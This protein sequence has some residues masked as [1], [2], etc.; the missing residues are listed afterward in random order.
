MKKYKTTI[1]ASIVI[2]VA[3]TAFFIFRAFLP[4]NDDG[5]GDAQEEINTVE[6]VSFVPSD[7]NKIDLYD[8]TNHILMELKYD[9]DWAC[10][11]ATELP[12]VQANVKSFLTVL[13][14]ARGQVVYEGEITEEK[15]ETYGIDDKKYIDYTLT[16][17]TLIR[18]SVGVEKPGASSSYVCVTGDP[19]NQDRIYL[20]T[21]T[22]LDTI[23]FDQHDLISTTIFAFEDPGKIRKMEIYK[24]G[25]LFFSADA[26][27]SAEQRAWNAT[28]PINRQGSYENIESVLSACVSLV[29]AGY[30]ESNPENLTKYGLDVPYF[31]LAVTDNKQTIKMTLGDLNPEGTHYYCLVS[32]MDHI[33]TIQA[34]TITFTDEPQLAFIYEY[35]YMVNYAD[36]TQLKFSYDG[37]DYVLTY[38]IFEEDE[39]LYFNGINVYLDKERDYRFEFKKIGTSLY[40]IAIDTIEP[41]PQHTDEIIIDIEYTLKDGTV[42][43]VT[44][45]KRDDYTYCAYVNGEYI[46]GYSNTRGLTGTAENYGLAGCIKDL[47]SLLGIDD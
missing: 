18:L 20:I 23:F 44:G 47:E 1:I 30:V 43:T 42:V 9:G 39:N 21:S 46:G 11:T 29:T 2:V 32:G 8:G 3:L 15:R 45:Y 22:Y 41:V 31:E 40:G 35:A 38:E 13:R 17:G 4:E 6:V 12:L 37:E 36:L 33:F 16:D 34:D 28:Y 7:V 25:E 27:L 10:K 26:D 14:N 24:K 19:E 5:P